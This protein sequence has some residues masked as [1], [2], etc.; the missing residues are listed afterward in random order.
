MQADSER[1]DGVELLHLNIGKDLQ[2]QEQL[3][4]PDRNDLFPLKGHDLD[5]LLKFDR[6]T[7]TG[8]HPLR[9]RIMLSRRVNDLEHLMIFLNTSPVT[10]G[11]IVSSLP[12]VRSVWSLWWESFLS[13]RCNSVGL[14]I[15][16]SEH[17]VEVARALER[18]PKGT[19]ASIYMRAY[20]FILN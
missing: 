17:D 4:R 13:S 16:G 8:K 3:V 9:Y 18:V 5:V 2:R 7:V 1:V 6:M 15:D 12:L 19:S 14:I 11:T 20:N 10:F